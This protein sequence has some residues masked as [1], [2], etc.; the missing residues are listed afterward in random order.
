MVAN[1]SILFL[2]EPTTGLDSYAAEKIVENLKLINKS[3][4]SII[5][6]IHQPNSKIYNLLERLIL[7]VNSGII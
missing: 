2:D 7:I 3:K 1:P 6:T 4:R 5:M